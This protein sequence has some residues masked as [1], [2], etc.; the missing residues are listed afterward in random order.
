MADQEIKADKDENSLAVSPQHFEQFVLHALDCSDP[1]CPFSLCVNTKLMFKHTQRCTSINCPICQQARSLALNHS[2]TCQEYFCC[3]PFCMEAKLTTFVESQSTE[4]STRHAENSL[5]CVSQTQ[6][7]T[8]TPLNENGSLNIEAGSHLFEQQS[9]EGNTMHLPEQTSL[10]PRR[11]RSSS[12]NLNSSAQKSSPSLK[13][14]N[15]RSSSLKASKTSSNWSVSSDQKTTLSLRVNTEERPYPSHGS[16]NIEAGCHLFEQQSP[17]GNTMHLPEQTSMCQRRV[18]SSS[19]NLNSSAQKSSPSLKRLNTKSSSLKASKTSSNWSVSNDQKTTLSSRVDTE[20][21]RYPS[22]TT[23]PDHQQRDNSVDPVRGSQEGPVTIM[24]NQTE[25]INQGNSG[26]QTECLRETSLACSDEQKRK[27]P[28]F[29]TEIRGKTV[30]EQCNATSVICQT[31]QHLQQ[32]QQ[33]KQQSSQNSVRAEGLSLRSK[34][35]KT[36]DRLLK[37]RFFHVLFGLQQLILNTKTRQELLICVGSLR[38][39]LQEIYNLDKA[40]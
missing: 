6:R 34:S 7:T 22:Q 9:L 5:D 37:R 10:C 29:Q 11:V 19:L 25:N 16:L 18:R 12:L 40:D 28:N 8:K 2:K 38:G 17:E 33:Q 26:T 20:E 24:V 4:Q 27:Y 14:L 13:R 31:S 39:A 30:R 36:C 23:S 21:R 3:V 1:N 15:T 32:Q 35:H